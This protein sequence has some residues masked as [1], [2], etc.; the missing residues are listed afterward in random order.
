MLETPI[1]DKPTPLIPLARLVLAGA[2]LG[3][4]IDLLAWGRPGGVGLACVMLTSIW[5]LSRAI[6]A[7]RASTRALTIAA[8]FATVPA[9]RASS[10]LTVISVVVVVGLCVVAAASSGAMGPPVSRWTVGTG[11]R[12]FAHLAR[13]MTDPPGLIR[14]HPETGRLRSIAKPRVF[15]LLRGTLW[16]A[17]AVLFFASLLGS[18]DPIFADLLG[19]ALDIGF[20]I[21]RIFRLGLVVTLTVYATLAIYHRVNREWGHEELRHSTLRSRTE[22][23]M[24]IGSLV[25]LFGVFLVVQAQY[26]FVGE[27]GRVGL[28]Y[29]QYA[30]RGFF[31]LVAVASLV[32]TLIVGLDWLAHPPSA[33]RDSRLDWLS[34][35]LIG[36]TF[37]VLASAIVRMAAYTNEFGLTELR[38]TTTAFML[39]IA[40]VLLTTVMTVLRG[41]RQQFA[42]VS[43]VAALVVAAGLVAVNPD[44][45]IAE[46]NLD[47]IEEVDVDHLGALSADALSSLDASRR[48][49]AVVAA[50]RIRATSEDLSKAWG[51]R[52][53]SWPE[54]SG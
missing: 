43:A 41:N 15:P 17:L 5:L 37:V 40:V 7:H 31:E 29:A 30:R 52:S 18:A 48:P 13:G 6:S 20:S 50:S 45:L 26:L 35:I 14:T 28:G 8:A 44:H 54:I 22:V 4:S 27:V 34:R 12:A 23:R 49:E 16:S 51:W 25:V 3:F 1:T 38:L 24:V 47:H 11:L 46:V 2:I 10:T 36:E 21:D 42:M 33:A 39:W 53:V 32:T 9:W 19:D